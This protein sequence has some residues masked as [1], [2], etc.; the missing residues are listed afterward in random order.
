MGT[1]SELLKKF[2]NQKFHSEE[3]GYFGVTKKKNSEV[4]ELLV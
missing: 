4:S 3:R 1:N 2:E